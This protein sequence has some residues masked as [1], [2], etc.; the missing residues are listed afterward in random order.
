MAR[1]THNPYN[2]VPLPK[3][4]PERGEYP[5]M[6]RLGD[7]SYSGRL[8]CDLEAITRLFTADHQRATVWPGGDKGQKLFPFLKNSNGDPILQGTSLK[9]MIRSIYEAAF[10]SCLP[11]AAES[12]ESQKVGQKVEYHWTLPAGYQHEKCDGLKNLCPSCSLFGIAQGDEVHAQGRVI[13][14]DAALTQ[15]ALQAEE[16]KLSELSS[17]KPH[18]PIYGRNGAM[19]GRKLYYHHDPAQQPQVDQLGLRSNVI[20]EY[21]PPGTVL[22]FSVRFE[23]L[24]EQELRRLIAVL[25][26]DEQHAHKLGMA[27]PLGYGS[28]KIAVRQEGSFAA[29]GGSRY[30]S[31]GSGE[32]PFDLSQWKIGED[33]LTGD[34]ERL[35][36]RER[37]GVGLTGYL[38]LKG[39]SDGLD[40]DEEGRYV[41][42]KPGPKA[43]AAPS[44]PESTD[45]AEV[46]AS[47]LKMSRAPEKITPPSQPRKKV[48]LEVVKYEEG[49]FLLRNPETGQEGIVFKNRGVPWR[50]GQVVTVRVVKIA[51]DG[52]I[53]EIKP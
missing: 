27:K 10:P 11:L 24:S 20:S 7:R 19:R 53:L 50:I 34:L 25:T 40:I 30:Q 26:L 9:G 35:L 38:P 5:G 33:W 29:K 4:G 43:S 17:P 14:S 46:I 12:G 1:P 23:S 2:F 16:V 49:R 52:R 36:R 41:T 6:D 51:S 39:Y 32:P 45:P 22:T 13:F 37:E 15:G 47:I 48:A 31:W 42:T 18:S 8:T 28:C 3:T 44:I 21:A